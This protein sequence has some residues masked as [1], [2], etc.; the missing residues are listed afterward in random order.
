MTPRCRWPLPI[1][2]A[3]LLA[4]P[5]PASPPAG[6]PLDPDAVLAATP[7]PQREAM[8][9]LLARMPASDRDR[10]DAA[11]LLEHCDR[12]H[13]AWADAPW[14]DA[15]PP[16]IFLDAI[17]PYASVS[18]TREQWRP[19]LRERT[20]PLIEGIRCPAAAAVAINA[21]LFAELGVR[22]STK[23]RRADASPSESIESGL[24]SCTGL[25][26]LLVN[27]CRSVGLP[28]RLVGTPL[29]SDGSG[30]HSWVEIWDGSQWR[31]TGAAEPTGDRLDEA[32]FTARAAAAVE[33][34]PRHGIY[35]VTWTDSPQR[36][37]IAFTDEPSPAR[38]IEVTARYRR[39]APRED[40]AAATVRVVARA[41]PL[42]V[43]L[44]VAI[45][46]P[47]GGRLASGRT[48]DDRSDLN[49]HFEATLPAGTV[50]EVRI[51]G[52]RLPFE[53]AGESL[54]ELDL[55]G[56]PPSAALAS[57]A[58]HLG[59]EGLAGIAEASWATVPLT[60]GEAAAA[61]A[62]LVEA[63]LEARR[64][65]R[66]EAF[67]GRVLARGDLRMPIWYSIRGEAPP[68]GRS[69]YISMHGGGEAPPE[70]HERQW[71]NQ[72]RLYAPDEGIY[73]APRAPTD[74][75]NL[76]HQGHVDD[77]FDDLIA[78]LVAFEQA[79]P[80]R[81]YL[82]GYSAGGDGVY[83]LAPRMADRFAAA[84]MMA[85]H[86]NDASPESLRNLPFALQV[87]AED[88]GHGRNGAAR[89]WERR[90]GDL[91]AG[92]AGGYPHW[93]K[94]HEGK[95]HWMDRE[96]AAAVPW[97]AS[98]RRDLRASRVVWRQHHRTHR[99]FY[100]LAVSEPRPGA[101]VVASRHG[102]R[103][104]LEAW[105]RQGEL[106]IRLDDE[107]L[108]LDQPVEVVEGDRSRFSGTVPRTI[109]TLLRTLLERGDPRGAFAAEIVLPPDGD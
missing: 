108:D 40:M 81:V 30:N 85:G 87:G 90:L 8:A 14:A 80:D 109:A 107:M 32:W 45:H 65:E 42:R 18:E 29:W 43:S 21:G 69:V 79:D 15:V 98:H 89:S 48:R 24:A 49:D 96:D 70:L 44:P 34:D 64:R 86:P 3:L 78:D 35:A 60:R 16:E 88:S 76:W 100:W 68:Q 19:S 1:A 102:S 52:R 41:G 66:R 91:A 53:A 82:M 77:F 46:G 75:W 39:D 57:L 36:F 25:S 12:A 26:I 11:F 5:L 38:A 6:P 23:R 106:R 56:D 73:L 58:E 62:L 83:Q 94:I 97:M 103:I 84:A 61:K 74:T 31:F 47:D 71:L 105:D 17:L 95:A 28:A 13:E 50:G 59:R 92:D 104:D 37:P 72:Q 4:A 101:L 7:P 55:A 27:A 33:G 20:L 10:V 51:A 9:W 93:V 99:R 2:A 22:Y 63:M 54:I 67:D